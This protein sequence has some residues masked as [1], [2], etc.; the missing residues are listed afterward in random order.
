MKNPDVEGDA[1][2]MKRVSL[3]DGHIHKSSFPRAA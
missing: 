2:L 1:Q 3:S